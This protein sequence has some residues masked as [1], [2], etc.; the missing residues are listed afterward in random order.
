MHCVFG[1]TCIH[2]S[3]ETSIPA[4][5]DGCKDWCV[6]ED[7]STFLIGKLCMNPFC[8]CLCQYS[9]CLTW[10]Y[11]LVA[12]HKLPFLLILAAYLATAPKLS[13]AVH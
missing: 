10:S 9:A 8:A 11:I 2:V 6:W 1:T 3:V 13:S 12:I 5:L 7:S 4:D